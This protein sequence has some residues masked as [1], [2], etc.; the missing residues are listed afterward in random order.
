M[1]VGA[2]QA[3][4]S[5]SHELSQ[6]AVEHIVLDRGRVGETWRGRWDSFC[7]VFPNW[8]VQLPGGRYEGGDPDGFM[9]RDHIVGYLVAY[10]DGFGAPVREG[11]EVS[12]LGQGDDG[13]F[14]LRTSAGDI[15]AQQVVV[16]SGAYQKPHRP[17]ASAELPVS[18]HKMDAEDYTNPG[19]LPSGPVLVVGSGQTGCQLAESRRAGTC[20]WR[21]GAPLG[22]RDGSTVRDTLA[23]MTETPLMDATL[24]DLPSPIARLGANPQATGR[25]A[26]T[27]FTTE[28]CKHWVSIC[29][30][31]SSAPRTPWLISLRT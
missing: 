8:T 30:D 13:R 7:L 14:L 3:G 19:A 27:T 12:W 24:D 23:W 15:R 22:L 9:S 5:L 25:T 28:H 20:T 10:A 6:A 31:T 11:V 4:L 21:V 2:G 16:A 26:A 18:L 29:W 17:P 1:V